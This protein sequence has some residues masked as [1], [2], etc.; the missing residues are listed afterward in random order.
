MTIDIKTQGRMYPFSHSLIYPSTH[1]SINPFIHLSTYTPTHPFVCL[2]IHANILSYIH[3]SVRSSTQ[4]SIHSFSI[5]PSTPS[6]HPPIH[7]VHP[8]THPCIHCFNY[9]ETINVYSVTCLNSQNRLK[10]LPW[11]SWVLVGERQTQTN[12]SITIVPQMVVSESITTACQM[13]GNRIRGMSR[14][15]ILMEVRRSGLKRW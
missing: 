4:T 7:P 12:K 3:S 6:T 9:S 1:L 10:Y 15:L 13:K 5:H 14:G 8:C 11:W 2:Y